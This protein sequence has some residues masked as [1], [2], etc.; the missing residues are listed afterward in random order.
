MPLQLARAHD[1]RVLRGTA[2]EASVQCDKTAPEHPRKHDVLGVV[3]LRPAQLPRKRGG[4]F[5]ETPRGASLDLG[6]QQP[7]QRDLRLVDGEAPAPCELA[8]RRRRLGPEQCRRD[9]RVPRELIQPTRHQRGI[10]RRCGVEN[11]HL[12]SVR[13]ALIAK[14]RDDLAA[15]GREAGQDLSSE[16]ALEVRLLDDMLSTYFVRRQLALP[17]PPTDR[18][19]IAAR[20]P[21]GL[22]YREHML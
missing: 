6:V 18:L 14:D 13:G 3:C 4:F 10:D 22:R 5:I 16:Q 2:T 19:W 20:S 21:G 12:N 8:E 7:I 15:I 1:L 9:G 17:D 11:Y